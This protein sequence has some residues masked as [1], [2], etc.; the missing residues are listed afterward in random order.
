MFRGY[1]YRSFNP[2]PVISGAMGA[3]RRPLYRLRR[4]AFRVSPI[5]ARGAQSVPYLD[6]GD[7]AKLTQYITVL[8]AEPAFR[9]G[10]HP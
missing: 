6:A 8:R 2:I 4:I 1:F 7:Q 5:A 3:N 9:S 10:R